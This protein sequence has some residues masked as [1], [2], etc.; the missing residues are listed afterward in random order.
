MKP[1]D[2]SPLYHLTGGYNIRINDYEMSQN[3]IAPAAWALAILQHKP[4]MVV[5]IGTSKGGLS[6]ILS[7]CVAHVGGEFHTFDIHGDGDYGQYPL[8]GNATFHEGDC[9]HPFYTSFIHEKL[10]QPGLAFMLCDGGNKVQEFN[11]FRESIK[12]GDVIA[13][14][15]WCDEMVPG[16]SPTYWGWLETPIKRLN[17]QGMVPFSPLWFHWS[18]WCVRQKL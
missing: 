3:M 7:E 14:H 13:A 18:A 11:L 17:L 6:A 4:K 2:V 5:E 1:H 12:R 8:T 9:F 15:D 16:Y 10:Q